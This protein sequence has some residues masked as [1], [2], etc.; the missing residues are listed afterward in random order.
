MLEAV[1]EK[2][3]GNPL[4][5]EET[6]RMLVQEDGAVPS[7]RIPDT[8]QAL[9]AARIDRLHPGEKLLLQR[10]AVVGRTFWA[11]AI[12]ELLPA[13][14]DVP[15][16]LDDLLLR[17]FIVREQRSSI[18]GEEAYRFKHVLIKEVAYSGLAKSSRADLHRRFAAW[19]HGRVG[20]ELTEIRAYHLDQA[21]RM[22]AELDGAPPADLATETAAVLESAGR[23]ALAREANASARKLLLR[24]V[25]LE[26][27]LERRYNA[28][29]AAWKLSDLPSTYA[30]MEA[31]GADAA[32]A[33]NRRIETWALIALAESTL[34]RNADVD[35]AH[36]LAERAF[37]IVPEDDGE[38]RFALLE[39]HSMVATWRG[40]MDESERYLRAAG[41]AAQAAGRADLESKAATELGL[42]HIMRGDHMLGR[43]S[44]ERG[45]TLADESGSI[46]ARAW[47]RR[48]QGELAAVEGAYAE[49]AR[50][51]EE[52]RGL[53]AETGTMLPYARTTNALARVYRWQGDLARAERLYREAIK[54]LNQL[55]DRGTLCE[56]QRQLAQL[57]LELGRIDEAERYAVA[58]METVGVQDVSSVAS[59]RMALGQ[60]RAAQ[61][62]DDE[63]EKLLREAVE[64][65]GEVVY[66]PV[67]RECVRALVDFLRERGRE[68]E[69]ASYEAR[70][71]ELSTAPIA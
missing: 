29:R 35:N 25:E 56:S 44:I 42:T 4:F 58:S 40:D 13:D 36:L 1:L 30:E 52:S 60:V 67:E 48:A 55:E 45:A 50:F 23:R 2:T 16:L 54:L 20:E 7:S 57:L 53:F 21:C 22:L 37:A 15:T 34:F 38:A 3:E 41:E 65:I 19:L 43:E 62:R 12:A 69:A 47:A 33:G 51:T 64:L 17:D 32:E 68:D 28:A 5:V 14:A 10:A 71:A 31:V 6:I 18:S 70:L 26:P 39:L 59:T 66:R 11:N 63:A 61:H 27:T 46:V 49:A 24:S 8:L 9:I